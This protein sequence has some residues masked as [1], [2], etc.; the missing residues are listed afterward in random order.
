[1]IYLT[2]NELLY[3]AEHAT[4]SKVV[5]RDIGLLESAAV[6]PQASAFGADAYPGLDTP[7]PARPLARAS[8]RLPV[9]E[10]LPHVGRRAGQGGGVGLG[11][12]DPGEVDDHVVGVQRP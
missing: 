11:R 9:R 3:I 8:L 6:R 7:D 5:V 4:G 1:M 10:R 2:L 12:G